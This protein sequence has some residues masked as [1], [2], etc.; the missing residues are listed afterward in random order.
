M[1]RALRVERPDKGVG[2]EV[3]RQGTTVLFVSH[4]LR[5]IT[6]LW[7]AVFDTSTERLGL[8]TI[9]LRAGEAFRCSVRLNLHLAPRTYRI[10]AAPYRHDI[11]PECYRWFPA[12]T[13]FIG[14]GQDLRGVANLYPRVVAFEP[15]AASVGP[16]APAGSSPPGG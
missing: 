10:G 12:A 7:R 15:V 13:L 8:G 6:D 3:L 1:R 11:Q 14:A 2:Q 9:G 5:A 4:N 16:G